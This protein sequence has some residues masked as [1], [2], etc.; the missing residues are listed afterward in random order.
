MIGIDLQKKLFCVQNEMH[1]AVVD[2]MKVASIE[3]RNATMGIVDGGTALALIIKNSPKKL[4]KIRAAEYECNKMKLYDLT[5]NPPQ[6]K[7]KI[8]IDSLDTPLCIE[9]MKEYEF[10]PF[11]KIGVIPC[12]GPNH[13][14]ACCQN[15]NH[16]C[17]HCNRVQ[18]KKKCC[19][20]GRKCF[21][22][23]ECQDKHC[24]QNKNDCE[25][26]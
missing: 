21:S 14:G 15:C 5:V 17:P 23:H 7:N 18:C 12:Q 13:L 16:A 10:P 3:H 1:D 9:I 26:K 22:N 11:N 8:E 25:T 19:I 4:K 6:I 24:T 2:Y 20:T